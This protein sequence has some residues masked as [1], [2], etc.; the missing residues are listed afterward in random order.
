MLVETI[1]IV[2][3]LFA[4]SYS[5]S[6]Y[7]RADSNEPFRVTPSISNGLYRYSVSGR[8]AL[9]TAVLVL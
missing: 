8:P 6:Y 2:I 1:Y 4:L 5:L 9:T 3:L 7:L